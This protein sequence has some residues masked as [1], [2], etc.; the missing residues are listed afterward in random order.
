MF[1]SNGEL[2]W[3]GGTVGP[4]DPVD[5]IDRQPLVFR[6]RILPAHT[7]AQIICPRYKAA[8]LAHAIT[9][10]P[11][12]PTTRKSSYL[13]SRDFSLVLSLSI[14]QRQHCCLSKCHPRV[15]RLPRR[16]SI[17]SFGRVP[18]TLPPVELFFLPRPEIF[19]HLLPLPAQKLF[20][21]DF[22]CSVS[23]FT[24]DPH[25][26]KIPVWPPPPGPTFPLP[27]IRSS[28]TALNDGGNLQL[29]ILAS[30]PSLP[31]T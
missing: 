3:D 24:R 11:T 30:P 31:W 19:A 9:P 4:E 18:E 25:S 21:F 15:Q 26:L 22:S 1:C 6:S 8:S 12:P 28:H 14:H 5:K 20:G 17:L 23:I 27:F 7:A 29:A 13:A 10:T 16:Q 2:Q